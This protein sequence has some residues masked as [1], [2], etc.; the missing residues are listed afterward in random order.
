MN[1]TRTPLYK[2]LRKRIEYMQQTL[3]VCPDE[4]SFQWTLDHIFWFESLSKIADEIGPDQDG[5]ISGKGR[6]DGKAD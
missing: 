1:Y 2:K 6:G 4:Q 5:L 3:L